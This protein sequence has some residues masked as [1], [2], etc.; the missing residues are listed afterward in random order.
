MLPMHRLQLHQLILTCEQGGRRPTAQD[1]A[2]CEIVALRQECLASYSTCSSCNVTSS[3]LQQ[4]VAHELRLL[5]HVVEEEWVHEET[6]LSLD[7]YLP[8]LHLCVEVDGPSHFATNCQER[9]GS[10]LLKHRLVRNL[11]LH[12]CVVIPL[13]PSTPHSFSQTP[14]PNAPW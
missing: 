10:T 3:L 1:F 2:R 5:G 11:G 7:M 4:T 12:L 6:G 13:P 9:L 14:S 8:D